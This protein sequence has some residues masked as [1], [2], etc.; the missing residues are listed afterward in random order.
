METPRIEPA[1]ATCWLVKDDRRLPLRLGENIL[2]REPDEG[3]DLE[4]PTVSRQHARLS[5]PRRV[6]PS[7]TWAQERD[8]PPRT[9]RDHRGVIG[10]WR[11][12]PRR[13]RGNALSNVIAEGPDGNVDQT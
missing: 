3:I 12:D 6:A 9:A 8:V 2:G 1:R 11:R 10:Q 4:S 5:S 7:R 13:I